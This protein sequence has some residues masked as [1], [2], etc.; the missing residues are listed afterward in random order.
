MS[1]PGTTMKSAGGG[2][3]R[4]EVQDSETVLADYLSHRWGVFHILLF[5]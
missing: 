1:G 3:K 5:P 4:G 2:D